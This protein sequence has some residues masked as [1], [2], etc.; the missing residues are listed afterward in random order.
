LYQAKKFIELGNVSVRIEVAN[1]L[2]VALGK[3][4]SELA[5]EAE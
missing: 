3:R 2:A 5:N 4:M 1:Q